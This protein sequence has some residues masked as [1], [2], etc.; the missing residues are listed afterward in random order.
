MFDQMV[1]RDILLK[2]RTLPLPASRGHDLQSSNMTSAI[3]LPVHFLTLWSI[4]PNEVLPNIMLG[5]V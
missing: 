3:R 1:D 4:N 2:P 5:K